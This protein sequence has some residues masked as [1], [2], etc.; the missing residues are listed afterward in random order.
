MVD[1][2]YLA[3]ACLVSVI[4]VI[5]VV[6][7]LFADL[8]DGLLFRP[9]RTSITTPNEPYRDEMIGEVHSR[10]FERGH[11]SVLLFLHGNAGSLAQRNYMIEWSRLAGADLVLVD[12]RGYGESRGSPSLDNMRDD[13][14]NA[15]DRVARAYQA[16]NVIVMSE[17]IGSVSASYLVSVRKPRILA[18]LCGLSSFKTIYR[19]FKKKNMILEAAAAIA[20]PNVDRIPNTTM[21]ARTQCPV[22]YI[23][24]KEDRLVPYCCA[25]ENHEATPESMR[26]GIM[27]IEGGHT[28]PRFTRE[29][30]EKILEEMGLDQTRGESMD[31][32]R[33]SM[34]TMARSIEFFIIDI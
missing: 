21:L 10:W 32:W 33:R 24:S 14:V 34:H 20:L 26:R 1:G 28:S 8:R 15:F 23:H 25:E 2:F 30:V 16:S 29:D 11:S 31:E 27:T 13:A 6:Y 18:M 4:I 19:E 22:L 5:A 3:I 9:I 7:M 12:Y 17:S